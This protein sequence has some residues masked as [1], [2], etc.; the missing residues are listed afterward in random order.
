MK[1]VFLYIGPH[2][3]HDR[4]ARAIEA[5]YVECSKGGVLDRLQA[6]VSHRFEGRPILIEGGVPLLE[7]GFVGILGDSGPVIELAAD[8][9]LIDFEATKDNRPTDV[10]ETGDK[11]ST[12]RLKQEISDYINNE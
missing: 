9:T 7:T 11:Y 4:M 3:V 6:G 12:E 5:E 8:T 2:P 1:P 10:A